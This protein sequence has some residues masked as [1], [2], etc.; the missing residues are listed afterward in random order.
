M[1]YNIMVQVPAPVVQNVSGRSQ[2]IAVCSILH[3]QERN[4][5]NFDHD[6]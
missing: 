1:Q 2:M 3:V 6:W 5:P 4:V